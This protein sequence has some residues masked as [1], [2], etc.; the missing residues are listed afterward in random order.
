MR[1]IPTET[2]EEFTTISG[3]IAICDA[4]LFF[5]IKAKNQIFSGRNLEKGVEDLRLDLQLQKSV[6]LESGAVDG[7]ENRYPD[8]ADENM[9]G[10]RH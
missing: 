10:G 2:D 1:I 5:N 6:E 8:K 3:S 4:P 7:S 9:F